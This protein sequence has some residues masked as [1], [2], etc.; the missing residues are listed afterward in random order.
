[1]LAGDD[2]GGGNRGLLFGLWFL[3]LITIVFGP[4]CT[5]TLAEQGA[6][7]IKLKAPAGDLLRKFGHPGTLLAAGRVN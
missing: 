1:M 2:R 4:S 6:E 3:D 5:L 7:F